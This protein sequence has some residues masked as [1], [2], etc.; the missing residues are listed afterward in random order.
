MFVVL[1]EDGHPGLIKSNEAL[2]A[3]NGFQRFIEAQPEIGGSLS[4]ADVLPQVNVSLREGNPRYLELG[5]TSAINGSLVAMLDS[6]SE[7][8][9]ISRFADDHYANV[10]SP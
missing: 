2:H 1:G 5:D 7:P 9:D 8:G 6:V 10:P 4:L 3:M